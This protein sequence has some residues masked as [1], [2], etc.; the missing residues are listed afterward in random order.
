MAFNP[1]TAQP[2]SATR[3]F[4]PSTAQPDAPASSSFKFNADSAIDDRIPEL[5]AAPAPTL[6]QRARAFLSPLLGET[7]EQKSIRESVR[8]QLGNLGLGSAVDA[9]I[10]P[11][12]EKVREQGALATTWESA[13]QPMISLPRAPN[14]LP[15]VRSPLMMGP[16]PAE[17]AGIYNAAAPM[18]ESLTSPFSVGTMGTIGLLSKLAK[19]IGPAAAAARATLKAAGIGFGAKLAHDTGEQAGQAVD[20]VNDAN[21][22]KTQK[23]AAVAAPVLTGVASLASTASGI[24]PARPGAP[25]PVSDAE[26]ASARNVTPRPA[27]PSLPGEQPLALPEPQRALPP[28]A[29]RKPAETEGVPTTVP[30]KLPAEQ[31]APKETAPAAPATPFREGQEIIYSLP[32]GQ[33]ARGIVAAPTAFG[34]VKITTQAGENIRVP[35]AR[36][37]ELPAEVNQAEGFDP[38]SAV[39]EI[40]VTLSEPDPVAPGASK[41]APDA[42]DRVAYLNEQLAAKEITPEEHMQLVAEAKGETGHANPEQST[43]GAVR[44]QA[45]EPPAPVAAREPGD[46]PAAPGPQSETPAPLPVAPAAPSKLIYSQTAVA[47]QRKAAE[48][49][50]AKAD[51]AARTKNKAR[52]GALARAAEAER[53]KL[54]E[55]IANQAPTGRT[56]GVGLPAHGEPDLLNVIEEAGGVSSGDDLA[57]TFVGTAKSLLRQSGRPIDEV[58]SELHGDG[59]L[60]DGHPQTLRDAV[61]QALTARG[62]AKK[63]ADKNS[64]T[65]RFENA[66]FG[67]QHPR[68]WLRAEQPISIDDL[69]VGD[70]FEVEGEKFKV[71]AVSEEGVVTIEDGITREIQPGTEVFPDQGKVRKAVST[72]KAIENF[73][74]V[75]AEPMAGDF[76]LEAVTPEQQAAEAA[77]K[78]EADKAQAQRD[79]IAALA[80][81]PLVGDSSDVGQGVLLKGDED[82]FSGQ[83]AE[84]A[85]ESSGRPKMGSQRGAIDERVLRAIAVTSAAG[86]G[87]AYGYSQGDT[88]EDRL[89]KAIGYGAAAGV[90]AY[91]LSKI[92]AAFAD[93]AAGGMGVALRAAKNSVEN[94]LIGGKD[95][96]NMRA[97][98]GPATDAAFRLANARIYGVQQGLNLAAKVLGD[99]YKDPVFAEKLGSVLVQEMQEAKII[100]LHDDLMKAR[101]PGERA[102]IQGQIDRVKPVWDMPATQINSPAEFQAALADPEIIAA[103]ERH[104]TLVQAQAEAAHVALGGKLAAVGPNTGAF[105]NTEAIVAG[106]DLPGA[107]KRGDL[108]NVLKRKTAFG[109]GRTGTADQYEIDYNRQVA[110]MAAGNAE[111]TAKKDYYETLEREGLAEKL[112]LGERPAAPEKYRRERTQE[113]SVTGQLEDTW[114]RRDVFGE[115]RQLMNTDSPLD[116]HL[117]A[118]TA[119]LMNTVQLKS[120]TDPTFHIANIVSAVTGAPGGGSRL[121]DLGRQIP[122]VNVGDALV[123]IG[124]RLGDV[125]ALNPEAREKLAEIARIGAL[126]EGHPGIVHAVDQAGRLVMN[127]LFQNLVDEGLATNTEGNRRDFVNQIG[128][129]NGRVMGK[130][131]ALFKEIGIS[132]FIVAGQNFNRLGVRRLLQQPGVETTGAAARGKL[133]ATSVLGT[134]VS[135]L[136]V[137]AAVN[138][139]LNRDDERVKNKAVGPTGVPLGA[140]GW[141][142]QDAD[143]KP[144]KLHYVDPLKWTNFRRGA[145][146]T[147]LNALANGVM[148]ERDLNHTAGQAWEDIRNAAIHPWAGPAINAFT[149]FETGKS[150]AGFQ[151]AELANPL[152]RTQAPTAAQSALNAKAAL[153]HL[154]PQVAAFLAGGKSKNPAEFSPGEGLKKVAT[155]LGGAA[156]YYEKNA[157]DAEHGPAEAA[158]YN[159][160]LE[161]QARREEI[162]KVANAWPK[163]TAEQRAKATEKMTELDGQDL[164]EALRQTSLG[165]TPA[166]RMIHSMGVEDGARA[167]YLAGQVMKLKGE[168]QLRYLDDKERK[169]LIT[170]KVGEQLVEELQARGFKP[171]VQAAR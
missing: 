91:I 73:L 163:M 67:N 22:T 54:A 152:D 89:R 34:R 77:T 64:F 21:A 149:I 112:P 13:N 116:N 7:A 165:F 99:K 145:R 71:K 167:K 83:S 115:H 81:K 135:L 59:W 60:T 108:Q 101:T 35:M 69:A 86:G 26:L 80:E 5:K 170:E 44:D 154:Q 137:P 20:V 82:L 38:S 97:A 148:Q 95:L 106:E 16:T 62:V 168:A 140:I 93:S 53:L 48:D 72:K 3:G 105:I 75:E 2:E 32:D 39:A 47:K 103:I 55:M 37:R 6:K 160:Q 102:K 28:G 46:L 87:A 78:R 68:K 171:P 63:A 31:V 161:R 153:G 45:S 121:A 51:Q 18:A 66:F 92:P 50:T 151:E 123:R 125:N 24:L 15:D 109:K 42:A 88:P 114:I 162:N 27:Q 141:Q 134:I 40:E 117:A 156:G 122:G 74:P 119:R 111:R 11:Q 17:A 150:V 41:P 33:E 164:I 147:G 58:A 133:V 130:I 124:R 146:M 30:D 157:G 1:A 128:Q 10:N 8:Q 136:A 113:L 94:A 65:E 159:E 14:D 132:P 85:A 107:A 79:K 143:G 23:V 49:A 100:Q 126:R 56:I 139:L 131:K 98:S 70:R 4:D 43:M 110:R 144:G 57:S 25:G 129:Y 29:P 61:A 118:V 158:L 104:K 96:P 12:A 142:D 120:I 155:S 36:V 127:D 90:A 9:A 19:G 169:G 84:G 76:S 138:Y 52:A 166:D